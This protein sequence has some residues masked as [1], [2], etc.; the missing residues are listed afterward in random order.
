MKIDG[1]DAPEY[2]TETEALDRG[3]GKVWDGSRRL[4]TLYTPGKSVS[5]RVLVY[6]DLSS[7]T[8][9]MSV[10]GQVSARALRAANRRFALV[11][12]PRG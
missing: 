11:Q 9:V 4:P 7:G 8:R 5:E 3:S 6:S 2:A 12:F 1:L 10:V